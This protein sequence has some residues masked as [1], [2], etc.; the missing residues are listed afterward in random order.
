MRS[1]RTECFP[2]YRRYTY[3]VRRTVRAQGGHIV[4]AS[5]A[6]G[7]VIGQQRWDGMILVQYPSMQ[8]LLAMTVAKEYDGLS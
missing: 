7:T 1:D 2:R 3:E 5:F 8:A 4:A 6:V